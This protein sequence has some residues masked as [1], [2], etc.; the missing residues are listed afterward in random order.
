LVVFCRGTGGAGFPGPARGPGP[1]KNT[2]GGARARASG[3][4]N[5][6]ASTPWD[7]PSGGGAT[8][9]H[10]PEKTGKHGLFGRDPFSI[11]LGGPANPLVKCSHT[12][13]H[14]F[15]CGG[16]GARARG[17]WGTGQVR[18]QTTGGFFYD[19][20]G[21]FFLVWGTRSSGGDRG[22]LPP[23]RPGRGKKKIKP[24]LGLPISAGEFGG[25]RRGGRRRGGDPAKPHRTPAAPGETGRRGH[26]PPPPRSM[27][28]RRFTPGRRRAGRG[29]LTARPGDTP[30]PQAGGRGTTEPRV[31]FKGAEPGEL[32]PA[33][34][35]G[36]PFSTH[37]DA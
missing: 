34:D 31:F 11:P 28:H 5:P 36:D 15:S 30:F 32:S 33:G 23:T 9:A 16:G 20:A 3:G 29:A 18:E 37:S 8:M 6:R 35:Y 13:E 1:K 25:K 21:L 26:P 12:A 17:G 22:A 10:S 2:A 27:F 7:C 19:R 14:R 24:P 4:E